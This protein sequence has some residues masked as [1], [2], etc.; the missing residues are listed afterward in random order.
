MR[1]NV[2]EFLQLLTETLDLP[3][4]V[5]EVGA[6]QT[7]GQEAYADVRPFF[8]DGSYL[9]CDMRPGA[10]VECL[11]DAHQLP[12]REA[13]VGTVLL[14]DTLEHVQ[15]PFVA[16]QEACRALRPGG[17]VLLASVM[18]FPIHSFPSDYWR[19]T[20]AVFDYLLTTFEP[21]FVVSQGDAEFP[22]TVIGVAMKP[23]PRAEDAERFREAMRA[24]EAR[25]PETAPS[26]PLLAWQPSF[27]AVSQRLAEQ[28]LPELKQGRTIA[29]SFVCPSDQMSRID[30]KLSNL[31]RLNNCHVLFRLRREDGQQ[32]VAS[33]RLF[34]HH[35]L[36]EGWA[37]IPIPEQAESGGQRYLLTLESPDGVFGDAV[38]ALASDKRAYAEGQLW[39]DGEAVDASL[40]FQVYCRSSDAAVSTGARAESPLRVNAGGGSRPTGVA[41]GQP[42]VAALLLRAEEQRW[43]QTRYL[44][45][46]LRSALDAIGA[47]HKVAQARLEVKLEAGLQELASIQREVLAESKEAASLSRAVKRNPLLRMLRRLLG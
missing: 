45:S 25:W 18:N 41:T 13:S 37:S 31:G 26:G 15:S 11:A 27:I 8:K 2:K 20:P 36:A 42:D 16:V 30:V 28:R 35:I 1:D 44:A 5:L 12:F 6:L 7:E 17:V 4:P 24:I 19:F 43:E 14:L 46:E 34:A 39:V 33:Y 29:Q 38:A 22:S 32:E 23:S 21:R 9:G 47:E 3:H 10:G 40:A